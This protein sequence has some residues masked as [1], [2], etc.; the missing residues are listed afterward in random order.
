MKNEFLNIN[1]FDKINTEAK[2]Y[3]LGFILADGSISKTTN[4]IHFTINSIDDYILKI[5]KNDI[6]SDNKVRR[7][8]VLDKRNGKIRNSS[9]FQFSNIKIKKDIIKHGITPNKTNIFK[10]PKNIPN[11]LFNHF[12]RGIFD[13]DGHISKKYSRISL[14]STKEFLK[15]IDKILLSNIARII[16]IQEKLNVYKLIIQNGKTC[17]DFLDYLYL[18]ATIFLKRKHKLYQNL[19]K[20]VNNHKITS[21]VKEVIVKNS[22]NKKINKFSSLKECSKFYNINSSTLCRIIKLKKMKKNMKFF[23]GKTNIIEKKHIGNSNFKIRL[24]K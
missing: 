8:K 19:K 14:I 24:I 2:A 16:P 5:L 4:R 9:I 11:N 10:T 3:F 21:F 22:N 17:R 20:I 1:Y 7:Y 18:N 6:G 23:H 15:Y 13:G 12:L